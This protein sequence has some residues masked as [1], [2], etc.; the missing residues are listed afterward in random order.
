MSRLSD[1]WITLIGDIGITGITL[2]FLI[3]VLYEVRLITLRNLVKKY[4]FTAKKEVFYLKTASIFFTVSI[5]L[6]F[7]ELIVNII[8]LVKG[9]EYLFI[10]FVSLGIGVIVGYGLTQYFKYYYPFILEKKLNKFRFKPRISPQTGNK[11]KLLNELEEDAYLTEEMIEHELNFTYDYDVWIDEETG[12]KLIERYDGHLHM[13]ICPRCN[14]RTM[15]DYKEEIIKSPTYSQKGMLKK[16]YKCS[17]C[18]HEET[19]EIPIAPI[20]Q[21]A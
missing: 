20:N 3:V 21:I 14:F 17:Y 9:F 2:A 4:E 8:G 7:F 16:H 11:M 18:D 15:K 19:K 1:F 5:T 12:Y 13:L 10:A 6:F